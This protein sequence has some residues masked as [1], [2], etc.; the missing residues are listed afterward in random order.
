[1]WSS[2]WTHSCTRAATDSTMW[3][4]LRFWESIFWRSSRGMI[5]KEFP[6]NWQGSSLSSVLWVLTTFIE[7][8]SWSIPIWSQRT[9]S[10]IFLLMNLKKSSRKDTSQLLMCTIYL[11]RSRTCSHLMSMTQG[12]NEGRTTR[13]KKASESL[14]I[15]LSM[16]R[17]LQI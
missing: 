8:V 11:I 10:L 3:W 17:V 15:K 13:K 16:L 7:S 1:M 12:T 4:S 6:C 2:C 9:S 14:I 5:T